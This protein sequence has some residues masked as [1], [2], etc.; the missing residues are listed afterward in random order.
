MWAWALRSR[1]PLQI[2]R[3]LYAAQ[4]AVQREYYDVGGT[5]GWGIYLNPEHYYPI[6][7]NPEYLLNYI[8]D[9]FSTIQNFTI[10]CNSLWNVLKEKW[11]MIEKMQI[12]FYL[13]ESQ[14]LYYSIMKCHGFFNKNTFWS[15]IFQWFTK[16]LPSDQHNPERTPD[17]ITMINALLLKRTCLFGFTLDKVMETCDGREQWCPEAYQHFGRRGVGGGLKKVDTFSEL[18]RV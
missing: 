15:F 6:I 10:G 16:V 2:M 9:T 5:A 17:T 3:E 1:S 11:K 18:D 7:V 12:L 13:L 8:A 14:L 4:Q